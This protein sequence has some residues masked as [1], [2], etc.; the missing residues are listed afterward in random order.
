M[1][2]KF[3]KFNNLIMLRSE[4]DFTWY[5][6]EVDVE[7]HY[8]FDHVN[9]PKQYPCLVQTEHY[10]RENQADQQEHTFIY[11]AEKKCPHCGHVSLEWDFETALVEN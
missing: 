8:K 7:S 10:Y 6:Q 5:K 11:K 9:T 4:R 2:E 1:F 3:A